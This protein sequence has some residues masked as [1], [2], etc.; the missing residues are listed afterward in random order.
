MRNLLESLAGALAAL[1]GFVEGFF[2]VQHGVFGALDLVVGQHHFDF[3]FGQEI[4][5]VFRTAIHFGVPALAAEAFDFAH[6]HACDAQF[7]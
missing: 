6:R 7:G 1:A 4:H 5:R 3:D 2:V